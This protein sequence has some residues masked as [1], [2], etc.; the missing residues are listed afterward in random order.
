MP[1]KKNPAY[2]QLAEEIKANIIRGSLKPGDRLEPIRKMA[3]ERGIAR[4]TVEAAYGILAAEG[5]V[6]PKSGS[7]HVV[8]DLELLLQQT[9]SSYDRGTP[10][11]F[12]HMAGQSDNG[13]GPFDSQEESS[14]KAEPYG[15]RAEVPYDFT[16]GDRGDR[17]FPVRLWAKITEEVLYRKAGASRYGNGLGEPQL[18]LAIMRDLNLTRGLPC[19]AENLVIQAGTQAS[20]NSILNLFDPRTDRVAIEDPGYTGALDVFVNRHFEVVRMPVS[21]PEDP[22][23]ENQGFWDALNAQ[24]PKLIF[25]TPSNQFPLGYVMPLEFRRKLLAW[26]REHDAY[27]IEDDYCREFRHKTR[28]LPALRS[29]DDSGRVIYLGTFSKALSPALRISYIVLPDGLVEP[30]RRAYLNHYCAVP[31]ITQMALAQFMDEGHWAR[32]RSKTITACRQCRDTLIDALES[33]MGDRIE[34]V[35]GETGLHILVRTRDSR[36]P[37]ELIASAL[38]RGVRVYDASGYWS[39]PAHQ[40]SDYVL[41]GFSAIELE[42]IRPGVSLLRSAWFPDL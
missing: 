13:K 34:I 32:H 28:A 10:I 2:R 29:L 19:K 4:N 12:T 22:A 27:I 9:R 30:W 5:F 40:R 33:E 24:P 14:F 37:A 36:K 3:Q 15:S 18:R 39:D 26:A 25:V 16:Y 6:T 38:K 35:G 31:W 7:G 41:V 21:N 23:G 17:T 8:Q 42:K 11:E 1:G 20:L